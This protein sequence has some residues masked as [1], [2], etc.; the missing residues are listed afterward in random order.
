MFTWLN[1]IL[2]VTQIII[3]IFVVVSSLVFSGRLAE[4]TLYKVLY[5]SGVTHPFQNNRLWCKIMESAVVVT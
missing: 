1:R 4:G 3:G 2:L 5:A